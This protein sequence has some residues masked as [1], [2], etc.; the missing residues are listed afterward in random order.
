MLEEFLKELVGCSGKS[1]V[2]SGVVLHL[3]ALDDGADGVSLLESLA[4]NLLCLRKMQLVVVIVQNDDLLGPGL[5]DLTCEYLADLVGV[6]LEY[7]GLVD[8]HNPSLKV[9]PDVQD[10]SSSE[11]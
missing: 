5:I 10:S 4:R 9:L 11:R 2:R 8:V 6:G 7:V 1:D 3:H